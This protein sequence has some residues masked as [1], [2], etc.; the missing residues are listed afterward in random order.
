VGRFLLNPKLSPIMKKSN[1]RKFL[2]GSLGGLG[3]G[4]LGGWIFRRSIIR[5]LVFDGDFD[6][7]LLNAAPIAGD[8]FCVLTSRQVEGPVYFPSPER[9]DIREDREG[10]P[11][12]LE[13][14]VVRYPD[15][16]PV[17]GA[18]V[19]IWHC[20]A[21]GRYSGYPEEIFRDVWE[22]LLFGIKHGKMTDGEMHIDPTT[23]DRFL[24]GLQRTDENGWVRFTTVFPGWYEG[25]V[26]HVHAKILL[27]ANE[28]LNT[29]F[30]FDTDYCNR[31]YTTQAPYDKYG[32]FPV[33]MKD[34]I[35]LA[36]NP[37]ADGLLLKVEGEPAPGQAL[38]ASARIGI[39]TA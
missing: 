19:E 13:F 1:R 14:Q 30:Y 34:D 32:E 5:K 35:V 33:S 10:L 8:D 27:G 12:D 11:F 7:S 23:K 29:Q 38:K 37:T 21:E 31:I 26:P 2:F 6:T 20:D 39:K 25:R 17:P 9:R 28:E 3:V 24:R 16:T 22:T 15:C 18:V 4:L 36:E